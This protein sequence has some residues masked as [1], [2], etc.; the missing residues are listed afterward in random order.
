MPEITLRE[1]TG[2]TE[3]IKGRNSNEL[4]LKIELVPRSKHFPS[5]LYKPISVSLPRG[6]N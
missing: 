5:R 1:C 4:Y 2:M 6:T 3:H